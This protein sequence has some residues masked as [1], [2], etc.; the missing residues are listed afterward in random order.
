[1]PSSSLHPALLQTI[2]KACLSTST[3]R[4]SVCQNDAQASEKSPDFKR[5]MSRLEHTASAE[6]EWNEL[7]VEL[8]SQIWK[9][10]SDRQQQPDGRNAFNS[11]PRLAADGEADGLSSVEHWAVAPLDVLSLQLTVAPVESET[12]EETE[13]NNVDVRMS[14][15]AA[16]IRTL[17]LYKGGNKRTRATM[18]AS[19]SCREP[20]IE[21][22]KQQQQQP[23]PEMKQFVES[24]AWASCET[25]DRVPISEDIVTEGGEEAH[26]DLVSIGRIKRRNLNALM[27]QGFGAENVSCRFHNSNATLAYANANYSPL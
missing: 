4:I 18:S 17:E 16:A 24:D 15:R 10:I 3:P 6:I 7:V 23:L 5:L 1:M 25:V 22:M 12:A 19:S 11:I 26:R 20:E 27:K 9:L 2:L 13:S 21:G 8:D 14:N